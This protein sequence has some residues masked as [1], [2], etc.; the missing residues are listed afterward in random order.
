MT[1]QLPVGEGCLKGA[2]YGS[3]DLDADQTSGIARDPKSPDLNAL[4][5]EWYEPLRE[6]PSSRQKRFTKSGS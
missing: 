4:D 6:R 2:C 1:A 5:F 3:Y